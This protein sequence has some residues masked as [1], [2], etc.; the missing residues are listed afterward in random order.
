MVADTATK[1]GPEHDGQVVISASHGGL[2]AAYLAAR[3]GVR[4]VILNDASVGKIVF[5]ARK[6]ICRKF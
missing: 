4:G 3:A 1:L 6:C 5:K 2:Y